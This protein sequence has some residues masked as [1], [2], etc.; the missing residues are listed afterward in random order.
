M[1]VAAARRPRTPRPLQI[2]FITAPPLMDPRGR[3]ERSVPMRCC[4]NRP[5]R[6]GSAGRGRIA[7]VSVSDDVFSTLFRPPPK[8]RTLLEREAP[9]VIGRL[10]RRLGSP[11]RVQEETARAS[12]QI[13]SVAEQS[14]WPPAA[15][16]RP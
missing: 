7:A 13:L 5:G 9:A 1:E 11:R 4:F 10:S 8:R 12:L 14:R 2:R 16:R 15:T 3:D 6:E